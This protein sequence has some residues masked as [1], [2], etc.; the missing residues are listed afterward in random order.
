MYGSMAIHRTAD[1]LHIPNQVKI[2]DNYAHE[3]QKHFNP[4]FAGPGAKKRWAEAGAFAAA[5]LYDQLYR[6]K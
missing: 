5:F 6:I 4:L 2:Y 1:S 3:L